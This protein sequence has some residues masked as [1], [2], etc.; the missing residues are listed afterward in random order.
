MILGRIGVLAL[1]VAAGWSLERDHIQWMLTAAEGAALETAL[2][3][4]CE[5]GRPI[6]PEGMEDSR[7]MATLIHE[8]LTPRDPAAQSGPLHEPGPAQLVCGIL[9]SPVSR[10]E[11]GHYAMVTTRTPQGDPGWGISV[12]VDPIGDRFKVMPEHVFSLRKPEIMYWPEALTLE[13]H[14]VWAKVEGRHLVIDAPMSYFDATRDVWGCQR[15]WTHAANLAAKNNQNLDLVRVR[16]DA[17]R[18]DDSATSVRYRAWRAFIDKQMK[19]SPDEE[20]QRFFHA[21]PDLKRITAAAMDLMMDAAGWAKLV[22]GRPAAARIP[23]GLDQIVNRTLGTV[24]QGM[25]R[26]G[27]VDTRLKKLIHP[28]AL[29]RVEAKLPVDALKEV[30]LGGFAILVEEPNQPAV[31][32]D[33]RFPPYKKD[34]LYTIGIRGNTARAFLLHPIQEDAAV[35][36]FQLLDGRWWLVDLEYRP[37]P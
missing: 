4:S 18:A 21:D 35:G 25:E 9:A 5:A 11:G 13:M 2:V 12:R 15:F 34:L 36:V 22:Q 37:Q 8:C 19:A 29:A 6:V 3:A 26:E 7:L 24:G 28:T 17:D 1:F 16:L 31:K 20:T 23:T 14:A 33:P 32:D 10:K 27:W 30:D